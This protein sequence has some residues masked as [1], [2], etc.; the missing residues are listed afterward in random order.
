MKEILKGAP[1]LAWAGRGAKRLAPALL[2]MIALAFSWL[3]R[4]LPNVFVEKIRSELAISD[5]QIGILTGTAFALC[6]AAGALPA[7]WLADRVKRAHLLACG[8]AAWSLLTIAVALAQTFSDMFICRMGVGLG[9][10][11]LL[12]TAYSL[13][14]DLYDDRGKARALAILS[15]GV[16]VG[17]GAA[18]LGGAQ[19]EW[20]ISGSDWVQITGISSWR[21]VFASIGAAGLV[22]AVVSIFLPEPKRTSGLDASQ[23]CGTENFLGHF[24]ERRSEIVPLIIGAAAFNMG[25]A[26]LIAWMVALISRVYGAGTVIIGSTLGLSTLIAGLC[27]APLAI[28]LVARLRNRSGTAASA[29]FLS[30]CSIAAAVCLG[31][32]H[33]SSNV[34]IAFTMISLTLLWIFSA[35]AVLPLAIMVSVDCRYTA[36][37][38]GVV[39]AV[40]S[41]SG[42]AFGPPLIGMINDRALGRSHLDWAV[43]GTCGF[44]FSMAALMFFILARR[45]RTTERFGR[46]ANPQT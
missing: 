33:L 8:I 20:V 24:V 32:S 15:L 37:A 7:G 41:I 25:G 6:Y 36:R 11:I 42:T 23:G 12:P 9:E 2:L 5:A 28:L 4:S 31:G 45:L 19:L 34:Q 13:I 46:I 29:W 26:G 21:L 43:V 40:A 17:S 14:N 30:L 35:T 16:P 22:I 18:L 39:M 27:A 10:A 3:D 1:R 44:F 38:S